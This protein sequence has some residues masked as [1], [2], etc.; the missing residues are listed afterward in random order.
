MSSI[1]ELRYN[2]RKWIEES[3]KKKDELEQQEKWTRSIAV[4]SKEFSEKIKKELGYN[5]S[6]R[7]II[8]DDKNWILREDLNSYLR[9]LG[10][11]IAN[12]EENR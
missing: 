12:K 9:I 3:L 2:R 7:T 5:A 10:P 8:E 6:G 1:E 4:G 11:K